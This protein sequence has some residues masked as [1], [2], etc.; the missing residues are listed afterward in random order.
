M[1]DERKELMKMVEKD[2]SYLEAYSYENERRFDESMAVS[3]IGERES[4]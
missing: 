2:I 3:E 1:K 4:S